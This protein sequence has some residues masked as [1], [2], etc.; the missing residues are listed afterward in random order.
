MER[1]GEASLIYSL[2]EVPTE[3]VSDTYLRGRYASTAQA[4]KTA[5]FQVPREDVRGGEGRIGGDE[6]G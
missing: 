1:V 4:E 3:S 2:F 5:L 6:G